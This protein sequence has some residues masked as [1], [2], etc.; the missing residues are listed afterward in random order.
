MS[1][2]T[3]TATSVALVGSGPLARRL[4]DGLGRLGLSVSHDLDG[5]GPLDALVFAPWDPAVVR[6]RPFHELTDGEFATAWQQTLDDAVRVSVRARQRFGS[7]GGRLVFVIPTLALGGGSQY[8]HWAA[9]AE[10]VHLLAK[11]ASRQWGPEGVTAN[12]LAVGPTDV[13]A[14]PDVAGPVSIATPALPGADPAQVLA[15]L[16]GAQA[17]HIGGQ[18]LVVDE[19]LWM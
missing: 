14:D 13:L 15:F 5:D 18:T 3:T 10:G 1:T 2:P 7:T 4:A 6:P 8:A 16:C 19:G 12:V 9:A 17:A 11:S